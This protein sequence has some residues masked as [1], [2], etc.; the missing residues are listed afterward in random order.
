MSL[1]CHTWGTSLGSHAVKVIGWG[2][3][4]GVDYWL[5]ANSW[6][7]DWGENGYFRIRRGTNEC[8]FESRICAGDINL[9]KI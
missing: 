5:V 9:K 1:R 7:T 2:V 8:G 4:K 6:N 3:D